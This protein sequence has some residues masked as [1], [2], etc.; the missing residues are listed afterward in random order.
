[1]ALGILLIVLGAGIGAGL[2]LWKPWDSDEELGLAGAVSDALCRDIADWHAAQETFLAR[3]V[4]P[5]FSEGAG[6]V[7][8][9]D[10]FED[11]EQVAL[12]EANSQDEEEI[13]DLLQ[14]ATSAE[15]RWLLALRLRNIST[16]SVVDTSAADQ[17]EA[18]Q[19]ADDSRREMND[20]LREA[21]VV[22]QDGCG[23]SPL[24]IYDPG[25]E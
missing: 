3:T 20:L 15:E 18:A 14:S 6:F 4:E 5:E 11:A 7:K 23:F 16:S 21:D 19:R 1:M 12:P 8:T 17:E 9:F 2:L 13:L 22:L 24:P 10:L 25:S